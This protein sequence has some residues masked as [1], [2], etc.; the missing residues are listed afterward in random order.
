MKIKRFFS[1]ILIS[2]LSCSMNTLQLKG[3]VI[4]LEPSIENK[5]RKGFFYGPV[6]KMYIMADLSPKDR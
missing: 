6:Q 2:I 1:D 5:I 3:N 4:E